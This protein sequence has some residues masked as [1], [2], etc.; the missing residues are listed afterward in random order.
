MQTPAQVIGA[1]LT[2]AQQ[3]LGFE[4]ALYYRREPGGFVLERRLGELPTNFGDAPAFARSRTGV[5]PLGR[6][7]AG[8][9]LVWTDDYGVHPRTPA[10]R[11]PFDLKSFLAAPVRAQG[12]VV[13][14]IVMLSFSGWRAVTP[15]TRRAARAVTL[16]LGH[17]LE[18][19]H[20][21]E[22]LRSSLEGECRRSGRKL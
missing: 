2:L 13:G 12:E 20:A 18:R 5:G 22:E 9:S 16:R 3:L 19:D 1:S 4:A 6:A 10:E 11:L 21:L 17:V 7:T 8:G 14:L 15:Q